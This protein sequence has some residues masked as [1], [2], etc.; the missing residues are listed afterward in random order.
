MCKNPKTGALTVAVWSSISIFLVWILLLYVYITRDRDTFFWWGDGSASDKY[1]ICLGISSII[2]VFTTALLWFGWWE[3]HLVS[4]QA[5]LGINISFL[6]L[7]IIGL[8]FTGL[9]GFGA[10]VTHII[11]FLMVYN[12]AEMLNEKKGG[13]P[14]ERF[15]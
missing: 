15:V 6:V 1:F 11:A 9:K 3:E 2:W 8:L 14:M 10:L 4:I 7:E 5:W 13:V 12:Y